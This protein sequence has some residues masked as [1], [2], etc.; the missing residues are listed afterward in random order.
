MSQCFCIGQIV[1]RRHFQIRM[2][3][4]YPAKC[5][6]AYAAK[7]INSDFCHKRSEGKLFKEHIG[8]PPAWFPDYIRN[9]E[10]RYEWSRRAGSG[11]TSII[12]ALPEHY[13]WIFKIFEIFAL[14][15]P[16]INSPS[17]A[18]TGTPYCLVFCTIS[19]KT[20]S[21]FETSISSNSN[22]LFFKKPFRVTQ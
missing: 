19:F 4:Q 10:T 11:T 3:V 18:M 14:S 5:I 13:S 8:V 1:N 9:G 17:M 22:P 12:R 15:K 6:S 2:L 7:A 21:S 16:S 20:F